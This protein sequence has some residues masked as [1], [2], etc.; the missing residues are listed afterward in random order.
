[1]K[2]DDH[3]LAGLFIGLTIGLHYVT[4]LAQFLPIFLVL[5][6]MYLLNFLRTR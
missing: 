2:F 3:L 1:M 4:P 6:A 5:S